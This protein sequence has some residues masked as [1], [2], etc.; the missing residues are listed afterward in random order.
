MAT[1]GPP[2]SCSCTTN[3]TEKTSS[4]SAVDLILSRNSFQLKIYLDGGQAPAQPSPN[5]SGTSPFLEQ[6]KLMYAS[7]P[8][9]RCFSALEHFLKHINFLEE[10]IPPAPAL[11]S[12][13]T[14]SAICGEQKKLRE[15]CRCQNDRTKAGRSRGGKGPQLE[16][17]EI[18][19]LTQE[20]ILKRK[21]EN[22]LWE[23]TR[24]HR[25]SGDHLDFS[26]Q[27]HTSPPLSSAHLFVLSKNINTFLPNLAIV[28]FL[29]YDPI[30]EL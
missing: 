22:L 13:K 17:S 4:I 27:P 7:Q 25:H 10:A 30:T 12:Q 16:V 2:S 3:S 15:I 1:M 6:F 23:A 28:Q 29:Q 9:L 24:E 5:C 18:T 8:L 19:T 21:S 11:P 20:C 14:W 26:N